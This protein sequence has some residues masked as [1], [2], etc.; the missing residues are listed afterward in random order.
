M[1]TYPCKH[2]QK[3]ITRLKSCLDC[4]LIESQAV[5]ANAQTLREEWAE[6]FADRQSRKEARREY[7]RKIGITAKATTRMTPRMLNQL[8]KCKDDAARRIL[9]GKSA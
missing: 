1:T 2:C 4:R 3:P 8:L 6:S 5:K 7:R 9:L